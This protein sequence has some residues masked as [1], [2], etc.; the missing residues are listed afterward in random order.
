MKKLVLILFVFVASTH[1]AQTLEHSLFERVSKDDIGKVVDEINRDSVAAYIAH[2]Q[3]FGSRFE[4]LE[5]RYEISEWI[6]NKFESFGYSNVQFDTFDGK[7]IFNQWGQSVDSTFQFRNVLCTI[8]GFG[9]PDEKFILVAH[10]DS[11]SSNTNPMITAPGADDNASGVAALLEIARV[12][13]FNNKQLKRTVVFAALAGEELMLRSHSGSKHYAQVLSDNNVDVKL[14]I[15]HDMIGYTN[16]SINESW[17]NINRHSNSIHFADLATIS[18]AN[19]TSIQAMHADYYGADLK[20]FYN[21]GYHGVYFEEN[22]FN[23]FYHTSNDLLS[24]LDSE[25]CT[26]VIKGSC[27][28]TIW[29][30]SMPN[31]VEG[32]NVITVEDADRKLHFS[33]HKNHDFDFSTYIL[34]LSQ[35]NGTSFQAIL[36]TDTIKVIEGIENLDN[37]RYAVCARSTDGYESFAEIYELTT[38][39]IIEDGIKNN[40]DFQLYQNYPNPFNPTTNIQFSI[41]RNE[42]VSVT[43]YDVL[44]NKVTDLIN[45]YKSKGNYNLKF[46]GSDLPSGVYL[47]QL[48]AGEYAITKKLSLIK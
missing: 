23:P 5:N 9:A 44:G 15:N 46:D 39:N 28:L 43:I 2:L 26:E 37:V 12:L 24:N 10:Y 47:C 31:M 33:W 42:F 34:Y 11:F 45:G 30:T 40:P 17:V 27:A 13:K 6:K 22:F 38:T 1:T 14:V 4:L 18:V 8:P 35:D 25:Y 41:P 32:I 16:K 3:Q 29:S 7:V 36:T 19:Y 20:P 21:A 48:I